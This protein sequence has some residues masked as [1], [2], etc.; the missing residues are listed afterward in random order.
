MMNHSTVAGDLE[1]LA[2]WACQTL[3]SDRHELR[4][5][6]RAWCEVSG[7]TVRNDLI[8]NVADLVAAQYTTDTRAAA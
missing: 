6:M 8:G 7:L 4:N 5:L 1:R 2:H 3:K